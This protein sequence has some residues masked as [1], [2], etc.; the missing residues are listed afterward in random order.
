MALNDDYIEFG[1]S[2]MN[3]D[4]A[5]ETVYRKHDVIKILNARNTG[6]GQQQLGYLTNIS[7]NQLI[8]GTLQ[9]GL[10]TCNGGAAFEDI[11]AA[12]LFRPNSAG[13]NQILYYDYDTNSYT[14][15][16]TD[17]TDSG[18]DVLL[19]LDPQQWVSCI[20]V[21]KT[22]LIATAK[23]L[24]PLYTNLNTLKSGG[25]GTVLWE[26]LSL[27]KPQCMPPPTGSYGSDSG[28]AGN[29]W[30]GVLPQ[31][32]VQYVNDD[33]NYSSWST[34]SKRQTPYQQNTP[35]TGSDVSQNNYIIWSFNIG[36]IRAT[37]LNF[38][39]Q[40][41]DSGQFYQ[42]K[43]VSRSHVTALPNT[44]V[45]V[46]TEI[47]EAYDPATNLYSFVDY[48]DTLKIPVAKQETQLSFD[49]IYPGANAC[50][51]LNGNIAAIAD[52]NIPYS[53]LTV[54]ATIA[55]VGYNPN[56]AIPSPDLTDPLRAVSSF[57]G[58][59]GSGAG[60][61]R[62]IISITLGGTP[63]TGDQI[64]VI[65]ADIRDANAT[66]NKT[67]VVPSGLDGNLAGVVAAYAA[68]FP[69]SSYKLNGDGTYTITWIDAPYYG[70]QQFAVDLFFAGAPVVNSI[71]SIPDDSTLQLALSLRVKQGRWYPLITDNSYIIHTPSYAQVNG[72]AV[73]ITATL[74]DVVLPDDVVDAQWL[75]TAP[76]QTKIVDTTAVLL[77][78]I[79]TW[80]ASTNT[81]TLAIN[82]S[83]NVG[84]TYQVSTP[85]SP[86]VPTSYH[87]I[88]DNATYN[89]GDYV[90]YNGRSWDVLPK[91][92]GD[93]TATGNI[94]AFS[95]NPL[96]LYNDSYSEQGV[97]TIVA[98]D[99][100]P[101][102]RCTLHYYVSGG[103]NNY[104]N[105]P[106]INLSVLGYDAGS[107]IVKVERSAALDYTSGV[108][109][110]GNSITA[111]NVFLR[112]YSPGLNPQGTTSA[113]S[114]STIW[115][116]I[117]ERFTVTNGHFDKLTFNLYDG[118]VYYKTR[119][120]DDALKPYANPPLETL[121][122]DLNYSDFYA[123]AFWSKGRARTYYDVLENTEQKAEII[124]SQNYIIGSRVNGLN[125]FYPAGIYG[126]GN[127][128]CSSSKGAIQVL[129]QRGDILVVIQELE[130][131]YIP[132]NYAWT[133]VNDQITSTAISE[134]LLNNGRYSSVGVGIGTAKESFWTRF[135][136]GGFIDPNNS[137]PMQMHLDGIVSIA[138]NMSK[139]F[140][141]Q[142]QQAYANGKKL[143]QYYDTYYE[144][145][146]TAIQSQ[147]AILKLFPFESGVWNPNDSYVIPASGI[148][149]NNGSHS[150]VSYNSTTGIA[151]YTP[152]TNYVGGD[153]AT[154]SF[155]PGT[156]T[157]TKNVCLNWTAGSGNVNPFTFAPR[158][159]MPL[160]TFIVSNSILVNGN[161]FPVPISIVGGDYS[162]D[163]GVTWTNVVGTVS[164]G[165]TVVVRVMSSA[166]NSTTTSTTLTV[167]S[168]SSTFDVT[169]E[170]GGGTTSTIAI[171]N[172]TTDFTIAFVKVL[173][174]ATTIYSRTT[175]PAGTSYFDSITAGTGYDV[176][177]KILASS[178]GGT[179]TLSISS[180]GTVTTYPVPALGLTITQSSVDTPII[181]ELDP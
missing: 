95:L 135:E 154:F 99:F 42:I 69:S 126:D 8:S 109:Y 78:Y 131:F 59:S 82:G 180:N 169:T 17:I 102:D 72:N 89:T 173:S 57:P 121:A 142:I 143:V 163:G 164:S 88:G 140:K 124:P 141:T 115:Y 61:H 123:S 25:Y 181:V 39:I 31:A 66:V 159:D 111:S 38:A 146:K 76:V 137:L 11:R 73:Q 158:I 2:G 68:F 167:D 139:Y 3:F 9:P 120:F 110:N 150:T 44:S 94:M 75:I 134:K 101:G 160:S 16:Y 7:S 33:F 133:I 1:G 112:L 147:S 90:V 77:N 96:K 166:S 117:G 174:G 29:F 63:H 161:D 85:A 51:V 13:N 130:V 107:Y 4:D 60:N 36:S 70:L 87:N 71:P 170:A 58:A 21:N 10:N 19:P 175:I 65:T 74:N 62:R 114:N 52:W 18:G 35:T 108:K 105:Q 67:Y 156:G 116:E 26:D 122:T 118:G 106:C 79:G 80:D 97:S 155:D 128:Q 22:Y 149:A 144:E 138:G 15:I 20:L 53:R 165:T 23:N 83:N 86:A 32:I 46:S 64:I 24:E 47:Y 113:V 153:T 14:P 49:Y 119:Q 92:F 157:I 93:L 176:N 100:A 172:T 98:Y 91:S 34:R 28:K 129:W 27:I 136:Q 162:L 177:V 37:T 40:L 152:D 5:P 30:F 81:P 50:E 54:P 103:T 55:A 127:G 145:V 56:I 48:N 104:F 41:D 171:N 148:T 132:V 45:N 178:D 12:I 168:Q 125:R 6:T 43:S 84:D 179:G 151:T